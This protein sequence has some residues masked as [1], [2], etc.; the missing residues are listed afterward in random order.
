MKVIRVLLAFCFL[1]V[2]CV[3]AA[4]ACGRHPVVS[5]VRG[6]TGYFRDIKPV[7]KAA[8]GVLG[9]LFGR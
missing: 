8:K 1:L 7:R 6:A 5:A 9:R 3:P 2:P 4:A